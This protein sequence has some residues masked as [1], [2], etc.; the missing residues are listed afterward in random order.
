MRFPLLFTLFLVPFWGAA[1]TRY[2]GILLDAQSGD[3]VPYAG[4]GVPGTSAGTVSGP[5]GRFEIVVPADVAADSVRC[6]AL[7]YR[8][9]ML[10]V[11]ALA[12]V[13]LQPQPHA[14]PEV[15][16]RPGKTDTV[17]LGS[18]RQKTNMNVNFA[19]NKE[20]NQN[21][22]SEVGRVFKLKKPSELQN[23]RFYLRYNNFDTVRFRINV[24]D[25][26]KGKP[27]QNLTPENIVV[28]V[29]GRKMDWITVD[30][31]PYNLVFDE[32]KI[33]VSVEWIYSGAKGTVLALP[34]AMPVTGGRHLYKFGSQN[35]WKTFN[36][37]AASMELTVLQ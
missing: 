6:H 36:N 31:T 35:R 12:T 27:G 16:V 13:R 17:T 30:L 18:D 28:E 2:A 8:T 10:P 14:L 22:G 21:L 26:N 34:I 32:G 20:Q 33:A 29:T 3:P 37:M 24:Y 4:I 23:M 5:D 7:G 15:V 9:A 11:S 25:F 19:I 1:Q